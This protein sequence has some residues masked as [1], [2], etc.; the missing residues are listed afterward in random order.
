[1]ADLVLHSFPTRRSSDLFWDVQLVVESLAAEKV[2]GHYRWGFG[3]VTLRTKFNLVGN[4]QGDVSFGVMPWGKWPT[5]RFGNGD[6]DG[7]LIAL[8]GVALPAD[9]AMGFM[10]EGDVIGNEANER[11]HFE[12]L[13]TWTLGHPVWGPLGAFVEGV[14]L[15]S[16][17]PGAKYA[18]SADGGFTLALTDTFQLDAG[19]G[20]GITRAAE[21]LSV[22][23]GASYKL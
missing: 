18:L 14:G 21:D 10:V 20:L 7:G 17:E 13:T 15:Y 9:F 8:L 19:G 12:L 16:R 11:H 5:A 23:F 3:D 4:D 1:A 6:V 2:A 22:F